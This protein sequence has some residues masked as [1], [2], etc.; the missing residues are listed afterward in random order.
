MRHAL[1]LAAR[2]GAQGE[3]PVGA[4]LVDAEGATVLGEGW[5]Q[6]IGGH[7]PTAHAEIMAVRAAAA[8]VENYRLT[9][10]VLYVTLEP[11]TMCAGALIHARLA[12]VVYGATDP[13]AGAAGS[14]FDILGTWQLN[15]HVE[16]EGG[17]LAEACSETLRAFFHARRNGKNQV[18][19]EE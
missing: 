5:N 17:I 11:C 13:K 19:S 9:G 7:D 16:V 18:R 10:A 15:H 2:A 6:P 8:R 14:V 3:V 1:G 4:V 12:R